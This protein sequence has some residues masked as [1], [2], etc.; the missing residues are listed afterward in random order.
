M[1]GEFLGTGSL[2]D[3]AWSTA[4]GG[5]V[6]LAAGFRAGGA[7]GMADSDGVIHFRPVKEVTGN[8]GGALELKVRF[9]SAPA[10]GA[11]IYSAST[12]YWTQDP[13]TSLQF[14]V[15]GEEQQNRW[16]AMGGQGTVTPQL[17]LDGTIQ[18][19]QWQITG[20]KWIEADEAAGSASLVGTAL[21]NATYSNYDPTTGHA[22]RLIV[23]TNGSI[24]YTGATVNVN[25]LTFTPGGTFTPITSPSG[26]EGVVRWRLTRASGTPMVSGTVG[27]YFEGYDHF[28]TRDTKAAKIIW[29][30][31]GVTAGGCP[32]VEAPRVQFT[33]VQLP[34][35][36]GIAGVMPTFKG[37]LDADTVEST[38]SDLGRSPHR[39]HFG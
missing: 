29:Y 16:V 15:E 11:V 27:T 17:A 24:A 18:T 9:P 14:I 8:T 35:Q 37:R 3:G 36:N 22:G 21:G 2:A 31:N 6:L 5:D 30:Q 23:Q 1:G 13:D 10:S 4:G 33:D 32:I 39:Y 7:A 25:T 28:D 34:D 38:A 12:Y 20:C 19:L 26:V